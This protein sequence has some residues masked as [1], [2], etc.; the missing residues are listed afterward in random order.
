[1]SETFTPP[2]FGLKLPIVTEVRRVNVQLD[3]REVDAEC[4]S[5]DLQQINIHLQVLYRIPEESVV[6]VLRD[7]AGNPFEKLILPACRSDKEVTAVKTAADIVEDS[8]T[9]QDAARSSTRARRSAPAVIEDLVI[10]NVALSRERRAGDRGQDGAVSRK[11][12]RRCSRCSRR[13]PTPRRCI[14]K[15]KADAES[16][17]SRARRSSGPSRLV[18][19]KMVE[20]WNGRRAAGRSARARTSCC[21][22]AGSV[23]AL[24]FLISSS[25]CSRTPP[26]SSTDRW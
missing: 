6:S 7:Y 8:R 10:E 5:S 23:R 20:K 15:A 2:G 18:E 19:L 13:R 25:G 16:T 3:T 11:P 12:R 22:S 17:G 21:R 9:D 26:S 1:M 4:F 14:I 24:N